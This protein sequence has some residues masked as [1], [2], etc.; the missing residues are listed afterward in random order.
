MSRRTK[1][2]LKE[3]NKAENRIQNEE[4]ESILTDITVYIRSSNINSYYQETV[5][6]DI[7]EMIA[8]GEKRG[9]TAR[10][11][12][13]DDYKLFC[14]NVIAEL[15][16]QSRKEQILSSLRDVLPSADILLLI[17]LGFQLVSQVNSTDPTLYFTVTAGNIFCAIL[18]IAGAFCVVHAICRNA[19][20]TAAV[21]GKTVFFTV[22]ALLLICIC[23]N[24]FLPFPLLRVHALTAAG[25]TAAVFALYKILDAKLD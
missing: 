22:F 8:D 12:I 7:L 1:L 14:D 6:R 24:V 19:F 18:C 4:N 16:R 17:W 11:I 2:L 20:D 25:A 23:A 3:N 5:R 9:E 21:S 15:P 10:E 13:G